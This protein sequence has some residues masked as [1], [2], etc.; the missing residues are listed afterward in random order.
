MATLKKKPAPK[1]TD[2]QILAEL[3]EFVEQVYIKLDQN[4]IPKLDKLD[5]IIAQNAKL[6]TYAKSTLLKVDQIQKE[7]LEQREILDEIL[8]VVKPLPAAKIVFNINLEGQL[9]EGV[10]QFT[11]TNS[12]QLTATI[13]P[14][15]KKGQPAPV[16]GIPVWASSDETIVTV[17]PADDG[18]SAVVAAVGPLGSAKVSVTADADLSGAV[19]AIFGTLDVTITQG[20]AVGF[21]ITTSDPVEQ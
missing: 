12:Q 6:L 20:Q 1:S 17:V 11:M 3:R 7:Q 8:V 16:D 15:D 21:K 14:V 9:Y 18:L 5:V 19:T 10:T 2:Q 4:C 13:Q